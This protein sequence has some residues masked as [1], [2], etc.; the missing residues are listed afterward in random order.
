MMAPRSALPG[1]LRGRYCHEEEKECEKSQPPAGVSA[2][3]QQYRRTP[4]VAAG[5]PPVGACQPVL[6]P[7]DA[8]GVPVA[9]RPRIIHQH[10]RDQVH[11]LC[12][13]DGAVRP[14]V[15]PGS[16]PVL[17][18]EA[19]RRQDGGPRPPAAHRAPGAAGGLYG[20]GGAVGGPLALRPPVAGPEPV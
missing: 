1:C 7:A 17:P 6:W 15:R 12:G 3:A 9:D 14:A 2:P 10:H 11:H 5:Q 13:A 19:L 20:L 8:D 18:G 4:A 16:G